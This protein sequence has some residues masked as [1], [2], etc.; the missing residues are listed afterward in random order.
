ME[1]LAH[2]QRGATRLMKGPANVSCEEQQRELG[3]FSLER[4]RGGLTA[5]HSSLKG[6]SSGEG[7]GLSCC[8]CSERTRG[9]GLK[10]TPGRFRLDSR[11]SFHP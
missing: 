9:D 11:I 10:L 5:L 4:A 7:F 8:A 2:V 3:L 1:I 6:G